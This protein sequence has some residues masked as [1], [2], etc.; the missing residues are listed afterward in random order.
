[1]TVLYEAPLRDMRFVLEA[2]LEAPSFWQ[3]VPQW[4]ALDMS[5]A[6]EVIEQA[7]R[8][9]SERLAPINGPGDLEGC[10]F[11][12]GTVTM[13]TGFRE[14]YRAFV[15][16]GWPT[17]A[18]AEEAGGQDL[19][20][21][22]DVVLQEMLAA[23]NHAWLMSPGLT[24]GATACLQA[25]GSDELQRDYLP[26]V[27]TGEWLTT[28]CLTEPQAGSDL[29]LIRSR[30]EP[31]SDHDGYR[32]TGSKIFITGGE[33]DLTDNIVHLVLARLPDA[34]AGTRG[35]S[36]FLVPKWIGTQRNAVH[37]EGI[38]KKMGLKASPTCTM[39]FDGARGWLVGEPHRGLPSLF[40]MMNAARLQVAMQGLGHAQ[41]AWQRAS[42]YALERVQM[43][44]VTAPAN[45]AASPIAWHPA[46]RRTLMDLRCVVE[47]ER[48]IGYWT[49]QWLDRSARDPVPSERERAEQIASVLTPIAKA[50]FTSNGFS[51]AS[52]A[53]QV[54]GG[55]G[56]IHEFGIEQTVRDSRV[57]MLYEGTNEIQAIDLLLR[58]VIG[59]QGQRLRLVLNEI[60]QEVAR[61]SIVLDLNAA[62]QALRSQCED[63]RTLTH[64]LLKA[65]VD[66]AELP[67][68][69]A[70]DYL[71]MMGWLLL[72][73][74][75]LR[76]ARIAMS[77]ASNSTSN[78]ASNAIG[79]AADNSVSDAI[80]NGLF[81]D[82][83]LA[84][85][86]ETAHYF[87]QYRVAE[88][89]HRKR[90]IQ[91][92]FHADLPF[93]TALSSLVRER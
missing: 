16:G 92:G 81:D 39:Q 88:F 20:L 76:S 31:E 13:P 27:A 34:P 66:D 70:D 11:E 50:F 5:T 93:F 32:I 91:A 36:L 25:H 78:P 49:A 79:D 60:E 51:S 33:H 89:E 47:G 10:G 90:L 87:F 23:A 59:D 83:F 54:F 44:A 74:A 55:Y 9:V 53:L 45:H 2:W 80:S 17:L 30:A 8:F 41:S 84:E 56:Y 57:S 82:G 19:P 28:M 63:V 77:T 35:L 12:A 3:S 43:R 75:W 68:R 21:V 73:F 24:H 72:A 7:A 64:A 1:M 4:A 58:K 29:G 37:C 52:S 14:A 38:E 42:A 61:C 48:A 46:M 18:L 69:V 67:Y 15:D 65:S 22:L 40:V 62:T 26:K 85:K 71:A 6:A 86:R